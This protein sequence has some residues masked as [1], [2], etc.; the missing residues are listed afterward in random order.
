[1]IQFPQPD[2]WFSIIT[3]LNV[4]VWISSTLLIKRKLNLNSNE[5]IGFLFMFNIVLLV[6]SIARD[7]YSNSGK[8]FWLTL[9]V[10]LVSN[11][12]AIIIRSRLNG[13]P[14]T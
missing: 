7:Q 12:L 2:I 8:W 14:Q 6:T 5:V 1:V 11:T 3:A 9:L 13:K 10:I 4:V